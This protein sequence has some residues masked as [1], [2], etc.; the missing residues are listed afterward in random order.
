[1]FLEAAELCGLEGSDLWVWRSSV[2]VWALPVEAAAVA[3][4]LPPGAETGS[5]QTL[6]AMLESSLIRRRRFHFLEFLNRIIQLNFY[7]FHF[8]SWEFTFELWP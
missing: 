7:W 1:M 4:L 3:A 8:V 5:R 6:R 2:S